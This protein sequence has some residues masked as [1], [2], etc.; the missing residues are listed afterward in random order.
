MDGIESVS[1]VFLEAYR[2]THKEETVQEY[3]EKVFKYPLDQFADQIPDLPPGRFNA[4][5]AHS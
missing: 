4:I 2:T 5:S 1:Q 3:V